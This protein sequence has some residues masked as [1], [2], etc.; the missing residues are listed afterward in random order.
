MSD[1]TPK[2]RLEKILCGVATV[3]KTRIEKAVKY[4]VDHTGGGG[5]IFEMSVAISTDSET[6]KQVATTDKTA[7]ELFD[8]CAA[9]KKVFAACTI[10][11]GE[12]SITIQKTIPVDGQV[13]G[14]GEEAAYEF[15]FATVTQE[16]GL[17]GFLAADLSAGDTVVFT[18]V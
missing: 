10:Q 9:G 15:C 3:A 11:A 4:F 12:D 1:F 18:Q 6:G 7:A 17:I 13:L 2:T 14:D 5:G 16:E 8:A